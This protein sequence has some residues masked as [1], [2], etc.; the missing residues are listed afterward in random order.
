M[1]FEGND[2]EVT[3][4]LGE[5]KPVYVMG[6]DVLQLPV[7]WIFL[8]S[9]VEFYASDDGKT[10]NL[11]STYYPAEVDD[12]RLDGPVMLARNFDNLRTR[13]IRIKAINLGTCPP[14]HPGEGQKAW[15]F[16]SEVE[17]E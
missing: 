6:L 8:P 14:T 17:I 12:I 3:V 4:D 7:S 16:V 10:Y 1:G 5:V 11:L 15:F 9:A 2:F 13:Y